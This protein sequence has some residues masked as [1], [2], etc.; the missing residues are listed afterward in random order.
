[1]GFKIGLVIF[2]YLVGGHPQSSM[3][4]SPSIFL[5]IGLGSHHL[6]ILIGGSIFH[7]KKKIKMSSIMNENEN[8]N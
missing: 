5:L 6:G 3:N 1:M 7:S 4:M 2:F 8:K